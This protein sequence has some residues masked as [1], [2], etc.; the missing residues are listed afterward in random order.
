MVKVW[1]VDQKSYVDTLFG[2]QDAI[3]AIDAL[4]KER[5]VTVGA[6]D[7]TLRLWKIVEETQLIF[8]GA[9]GTQ[10]PDKMT[11]ETIRTDESLDGVA[12]LDEEHFVT[13]S[14]AGAIAL[15]SVNKK[16][17][18]FRVAEAH[19]MDAESGTPRWVTSIAACTYTDVFCTGSYD[20]QIRVWGIASNWQSFSL[21]CTIPMY[22]VVNGLHMMDHQDT[23]KVGVAVGREHKLGRWIS[24]SDA[25]DSA[26]FVTIKLT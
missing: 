17:P 14:Q 18:L 3:T 9:S 2:H 13:G 26:H 21:T 20:G 8:R 1:D 24:I 5:C 22:G 15:W 11:D 19:G 7:R 6:R 4:S 23:L 16:K 12:M 10:N 25:K